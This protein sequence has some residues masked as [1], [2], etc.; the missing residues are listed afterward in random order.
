MGRPGGLPGAGKPGLRADIPMKGLPRVR[1]G[2][3]WNNRALG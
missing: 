3:S 1:C 2:S